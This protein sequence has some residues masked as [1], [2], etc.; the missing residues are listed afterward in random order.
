M[1]PGRRSAEID[2]GDGL[3]IQEGKREMSAWNPIERLWQDFRYAIRALRR[4]PGFTAVALLSLALGI[5]ANTS[6]F[7][8]INTLVLRMLPVPEPQQ[9]VEFLIL[10]PGDPPLNVFSY[11][12]YEYFRD[13]NHVF[14][15]LTGVRPARFNVRGDGL[16]PEAADGES[17]VGN[18][19]Q[20]LGVK[21]AIGRLIAPGDS[22]VA[23]VSWSYWNNKFNHDPA[24]LGKRI[25]VE[26]VPVTIVGVTPREFF[27]VQVGVRPDIW[28]PLGADHTAP[29]QLIGRLRPGVSIE[30][31][32]AEMA[33]LFR[34]TLEE[35]TR[36]SN[37]P[38]MH[39]LKFEVRPAGAGLATGLRDQFA[40]PLLALMAVVGLLLLI[41]CIN[42]ANMLLARGSARRH[43][44]A[45]RVALGAGRLRL[46]RQVL[47]ESL[48][49]SA[50]GGLL[51]I[52]LASFGAGALVRI[53]TSG[54]QM[55]G[56]RIEI[57][58]HPDT[59]VL[60]F[61]GGVALL[62]G[63]LFGLAPAWNAFASR[64]ASSL[65]EIGR[66]GETRLG[67]IFGKSLVVA[68]V[69]LSVALVS[70]AGLFIGHLSNLE[71]LD[72][73]FR[74]DHVL[75]VT[76]DPARSGYSDEQLSRAYQELLGRLDTI[77]GVCSATISA[78]TPL[79][80]AGAGRFVTVESNPERP[81]DR[82]YVSVSWVAPKYFETLGTPLLA[83]R[84]FSF[85]D[86]DK[87]RVAIVN[88]AM[89]RHYFGGGDPIGKYVTF[90]GDTKP[91]EIVG[92]A[93]DAKYYEIREAAPRTVYLDAFHIPRPP[94][95]FALRTSIDP[96]AV[97]PAIGRIV[98]ELLKDVP[99]V[100]VTTLA[101][102][103]DATI[104][105]ER[106]IATLSGL[107]GALGSLLAAIG[108]YGLLAYTV[109]RRIHEIGIRMA[110]GATRGAVSRMVLVE[111]LVMSSGGLGIG[112][113]IA[114][115]G[116]RLAGSLIQD[117][118]VESAFPLAFGAVMMI[119]ITLLAAYLPARRAARVDP[120]EA[121]R[122]E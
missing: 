83:G 98:R 62:T 75:L 72:L 86:R 54:R 30:Q 47:A 108:I 78:P 91:Y 110:L 51:A 27:G 65:R 79:S 90:D 82:R 32:R 109:A 42:L 58:V 119:A 26:D 33:V 120:M 22:A 44:M 95:T 73:G 56:P 116:K 53:M 117:L 50:A 99:V 92:V 115:W 24:I 29:L 57:Q 74:R 14:S 67:R 10:Y 55:P 66:A 97:A 94:A 89:A 8:L 46:M 43:E 121:L 114:Y 111:A 17:V 68:Q 28:V 37:D 118:P 101:D 85:E 25:I 19:F 61:T 77:P 49:L 45:V 36:A 103:V 112:V 88:E 12:S 71:H 39:Q 3:L 35:R 16:E 87:A 113:L 93:G 106:L 60:L 84:D 40:N 81:E 2:I 9:L 18:I 80:G 100:R 34:W 48:L 63:L 7:S 52:I 102:Q 6:I 15:G 104:V 122:Y 31:A 5:G 70:A 76:L 21:P 107:F 59:H 69:A 96:R 1:A 38:V 105:P 64:P 20:M 11:Q 4:S 13:H 41:A 23:V